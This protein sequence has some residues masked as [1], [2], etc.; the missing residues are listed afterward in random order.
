MVALAS[1]TSSAVAVRGLDLAGLDG[2]RQLDVALEL[3]VPALQTVV[4]LVLGLGRGLPLALHRQHFTGDGDR[5]FLLADTRDVAGNDQVVLGLVHVDRRRPD[6]FGHRA[7]A[8]R[9]TEERVEQAVHLA[10][11][12]T[13]LRFP[14]GH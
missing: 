2:N 9:M 11:G 12:E 10:L 6:P 8:G 14:A 13:S 3:P 5:H 7:A 1:L 4:A